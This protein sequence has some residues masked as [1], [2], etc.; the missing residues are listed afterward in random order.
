VVR[1]RRTCRRL[2]RPGKVNTS[3]PDS[4]N[5]KAFRGYVEGYNAQALVTEQ[6]IIVAAEVNTDP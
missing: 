4:K 6:Q 3:D 1:R 2:S 5:V